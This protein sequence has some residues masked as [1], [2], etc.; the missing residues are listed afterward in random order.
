MLA[1]M[2]INTDRVRLFRGS[3]CKQEIV[4]T[5]EVSVANAEKSL[6]HKGDVSHNP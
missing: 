5:V 2:L 6:G 4:T 3:T 1:S